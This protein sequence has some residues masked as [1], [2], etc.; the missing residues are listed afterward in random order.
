MPGIQSFFRFFASFCNGQ[1][2]R[3]QYDGKAL[4]RCSEI[5]GRMSNQ[6]T[7]RDGKQLGFNNQTSSDPK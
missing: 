1:I 5:V 4:V 3:Q 7:H 2:I 6:T